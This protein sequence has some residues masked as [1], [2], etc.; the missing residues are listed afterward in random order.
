MQ[1]EKVDKRRKSIKSEH[2]KSKNDEKKW[3]KWT[4]TE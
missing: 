4:A 2:N 1:K 3:R